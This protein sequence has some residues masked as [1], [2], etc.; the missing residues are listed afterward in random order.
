MI[1][2]GAGMAGLLA[3][4][5]LRSSATSVLEAQ[6]TIPN[7]HS[8]VLRFRSDIVAQVLGIEFKAVDAMKAIHQWSN[9]L[10]D[11][12]A[13]SQK[14]T[15]SS[16][17][18]SIITADNKLSRRF[19]APPDLISQMIKSIHCPIHLDRSVKS[20]FLLN[21]DAPRPSVISTIPMPTMMKLLQW[22]K[23]DEAVP[24]F[25]WSDGYNISFRVRGLEAYAS[26]YVP[27]PD[28]EEN[29]ISITGDRV[30]I[31][32]S[33]PDTDPLFVDHL[34]DDYKTD[35][36]SAEFRIE[37]AMDML[38]LPVG[39]MDELYHDVS[40]HRQKYSKILPV[41]ESIRREFIMWASKEHSVYS[42]GR[43]ATWRPG[44]LLDDLVND[45]RVIQRI[46]SSPSSSYPYNK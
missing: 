1:V 5:I 24:L 18:R 21:R 26:L 23:A 19:I 13:Y 16:T 22:P 36:A 42:L 43:Y 34:V 40:V 6:S 14:T 28:L 44:L 27:A 15:G 11:A 35:G 39:R 38:G 9:P 8:A 12:L 32:T 10:A 2:L 33:L 31:E 7:N 45:V 3:A 17:L 37:R 4:A 25:R 29:R 30:T 46:S 20:E 41:D